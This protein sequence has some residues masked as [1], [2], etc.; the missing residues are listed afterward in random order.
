MSSVGEHGSEGPNLDKAREV[1]TESILIE[2]IKE[3][4][5]DFSQK[6]KDDEIPNVNILLSERAVSMGSRIQKR[7]LEQLKINTMGTYIKEVRKAKGYDEGE[8]A[9][10]AKIARETFSQL[11][12]DQMKFHNLSAQK[13]ANLFE[14]LDLN[15][16]LIIGFLKNSEETINMLQPHSSF[17]RTKSSLNHGEKET[18]TQSLS[19]SEDQSVD[20][21]LNDF[22]E[23]LKNRGIV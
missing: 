20:N 3:G 9:K 22:F 10:Q 13:A 5:L 8:V 21:F 23:E 18:M 1:E 4:L 14:F 17:Y 12:H 2:L 7:V 16:H 11:E 19:M 6:P 15:L